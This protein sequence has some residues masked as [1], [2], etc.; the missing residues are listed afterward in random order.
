MRSL[1]LS[2]CRDLRMGGCDDCDLRNLR[3]LKLTSVAYYA[4]DNSD[5]DV[6]YTLIYQTFKGYR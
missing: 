4:Q 3:A 6:V 1:I 5:V 2:L